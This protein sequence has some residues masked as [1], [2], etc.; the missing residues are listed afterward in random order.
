MR[1]KT[2]APRLKVKYLVRYSLSRLF[3]VVALVDDI[4]DFLAVH[5]EIDAVCGQSQESVV[6]MV[7]LKE[8]ITFKN[9]KQFLCG[10]FIVNDSLDHIY[11]GG[12]MITVLQI[13]VN[14]YV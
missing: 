13:R 11:D 8:K 3:R 6:G 5:N 4:A 1:H 9:Q 14:K 7:Q 12:E 2:T 10:I